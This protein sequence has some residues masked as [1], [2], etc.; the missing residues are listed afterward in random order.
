M[1]SPL[2]QGSTLRTDVCYRQSRGADKLQLARN[3]KGNYPCFPVGLAE[4]ILEAAFCPTVTVYMYIA[5]L[6][7]EG[8]LNPVACCGCG[9]MRTACFTHARAECA[10]CTTGFKIMEQRFFKTEKYFHPESFIFQIKEWS[11][12]SLL[13]I[14][15][16]YFPYTVEFSQ[17]L[18]GRGSPYSFPTSNIAFVVCS[19]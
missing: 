18:Q 16:L 15:R 2:A 19:K 1:C 5:Y 17:L 6:F 12:I 13:V 3:A 10:S 14:L 11:M 4:G 7:H 9:Y 8:L